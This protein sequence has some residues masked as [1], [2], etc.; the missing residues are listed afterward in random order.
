M[1]RLAAGCPVL[2]LDAP[3]PWEGRFGHMGPEDAEAA[4]GQWP[5]TTLMAT[6]RDDDVVRAEHADFAFPDDGDVFDSR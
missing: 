6:H 2:V 1:D 3:S 5:E 4:A